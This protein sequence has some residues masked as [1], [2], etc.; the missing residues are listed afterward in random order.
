MAECVCA[1]TALH[2]QVDIHVHAHH[3]GYEWRRPSLALL[4]LLRQVVA[5]NEVAD[6]SH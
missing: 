1:F 4:P 2:K 3:C 6:E 5:G